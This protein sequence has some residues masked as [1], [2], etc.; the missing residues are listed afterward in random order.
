MKQSFIIAF[1]IGVFLS[2]YGFFTPAP[3]SAE[4]NVNVTVPLPGLVIPAPP[5]LFVIPG[6]YVYFPPDVDVDIFFYHGYWYRPY[7][8]GWYR[9]EGYNGPWHTIHR[10]RVPRAVINLPPTYRRVPSGHERLP[11]GAVHKNWR[12]W[13]RERHWDRHREGNGRGSYGDHDRR[14]GRNGE[15]DRN[16]GGRHGRH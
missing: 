14:R 4:V 1:V 12:N 16:G 8:G 7:R 15:R 13:E 5:P 3:A 6:T 2:A 10:S 9:S 11:F